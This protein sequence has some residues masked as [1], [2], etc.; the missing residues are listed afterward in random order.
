MIPDRQVVVVRCECI[1]GVSENDTTVVRMV[2]ADEEVGIVSYREGQMVLHTLQRDESFFLQVAVVLQDI[3]IGPVIQQDTL[4][5]LPDNTVNRTAQCR[6]VIQSSRGK[7]M[8]MRL[9]N[10]KLREAIARGERC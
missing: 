7:D 6:E 2:T 4:K 10:G 5:V 1:L 3:R 9:D 8:L